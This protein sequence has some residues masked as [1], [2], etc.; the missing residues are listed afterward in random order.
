VILFLG[1]SFVYVGQKSSAD[2][3]NEIKQ[4]LSAQLPVGASLKTVT[5]YLNA[6]KIEYY[7]Y[8]EKTNEITARFRNINNSWLVITDLRVTFSFD[9]NKRLVNLLYKEEL[10]GP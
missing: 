6:N 5:A 4:T 1:F 9:Q 3:E 8:D 2:K 10:T 7:Q